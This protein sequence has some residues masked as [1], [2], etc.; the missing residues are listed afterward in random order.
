[1]DPKVAAVVIMMPAMATAVVA[2]NHS[3]VFAKRDLITFISLP[4]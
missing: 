2:R 3:S 1:V 4:I